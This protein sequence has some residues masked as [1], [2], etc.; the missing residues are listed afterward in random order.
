KG[1]KVSLR[2]FG[3]AA[4]RVPKLG[5][6]AFGTEALT[7]ALPLPPGAVYNRTPR[8]TMLKDIYAQCD[9]WLSASWDEG[10][11]LPPLEAMACRCP[12]GVGWLAAPRAGPVSSLAAPPCRSGGFYLRLALFASRLLGH[13]P[14]P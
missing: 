5:L 11:G 9:V 6:V 13:S 10:F 1:C 7:A 3:L 8:Q 2:A 12:G 4:G 14:R